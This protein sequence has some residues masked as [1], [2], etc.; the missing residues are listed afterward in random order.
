MIQI[1]RRPPAGL[2]WRELQRSDVVTVRGA[3]TYRE[4]RLM[5]A[6]VTVVGHEPDVETYDVVIVRHES[7]KGGAPSA[8]TF[9]PGTKLH[10]AVKPG[11]CGITHDGM[12][13]SNDELAEFAEVFDCAL[14]M[15]AAESDDV[16]YATTSP[17]QVGDTWKMQTDRLAAAIGDSP[18]FEANEMKF[19][20]IDTIDGRQCY[21]L[22]MSYRAS[23]IVKGAAIDHTGISSF[24]LPVDSQ[25]PALQRAWESHDKAAEGETTRTATIKRTIKR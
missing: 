7:T 14:P 18:E 8:G 11:G 12:P 17:H 22:S 21:V 2:S 1:D 6:D 15:T 13:V 9:A 3:A 23:N 5:E 10:V 25:L 19:E 24:T 4:H 16:L 20:R